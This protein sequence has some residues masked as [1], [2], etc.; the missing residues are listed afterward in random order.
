MNKRKY[1]AL[2]SSTMADGALVRCFPE[3]GETTSIGP[4][5]DQGNR[6]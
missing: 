6:K 5:D 4:A 1:Q 2:T 3:A